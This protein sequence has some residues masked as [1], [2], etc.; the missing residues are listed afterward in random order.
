L[1]RQIS[2]QTIE[3]DSDSAAPTDSNWQLAYV[4]IRSASSRSAFL[5]AAGQKPASWQEAYMPP[6]PAA[7]CCGHVHR[8][9]ERCG[10]CAALLYHFVTDHIAAKQKQSSAA[11]T[12]LSDSAL[13]GA[14]H[15]ARHII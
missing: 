2:W 1:Q 9:F 6:A 15:V 3:S 8:T 13:K 12:K 4:A 11:L 7:A 5:H 14:V 10:R